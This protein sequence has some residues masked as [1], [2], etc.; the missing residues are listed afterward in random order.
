[1][2]DTPSGGKTGQVALAA[3]ERNQTENEFTSRPAAKK[4]KPHHWE[5]V[6]QRAKMAA[7]NGISEQLRDAT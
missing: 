1:M 5:P 7:A 4:E 2:P 3:T 6:H